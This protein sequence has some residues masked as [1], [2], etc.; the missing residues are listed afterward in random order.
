M[1]KKVLLKGPILTASGY[2]EHCRMIYRSL[3][4]ASEQ[5]DLFLFPTPWGQTGW[6]TSDDQER[7]DIDALIQKSVSYAQ[8]GGL[9]DVSV[10]VMIP[11]EFERMAPVNIG[12]TAG[13]ETNKVSPDWLFKAFETV[14]KMIVPSEFS[15]MGFLNSSAIASDQNGIQ[16]TIRYDKPIEVI[17]YPVKNI[18]IPTESKS[19][20]DFKTDFNFL[21]VAQWGPRKNLENTI[22]WFVEEFRNE[23]N[24]GLVVKATKLKGSNID[25]EF[26]IDELK[27]LLN[28][29]GEHKCKVYLLHGA[30]SEEDMHSL[31]VHPKIKALVSFSHGEGYGLPL[32][33]AAYSAL[34]VITHDFGGQK[35][36]L[37]VL[38]DGKLKFKAVKV[39]YDVKNIQ[40][41]AHWPTVLNPDMFWA[42]PRSVSCKK[43]MREV[44]KDYGRFKAQA[45]KLKEAI[46]AN[47]DEE[48]VHSIFISSLEEYIKQDEA[49]LEWLK[50]LDSTQVD[51]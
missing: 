11:S 18:K 10:Q 27:T 38:E 22:K 50:M 46:V 51:K 35:D 41:E 43:T 39:E 4:K 45:K 1:K 42:F 3:Q 17:P 26:C 30:L 5:V 2:G 23:E 14:D 29:F 31:Y 37:S 9:F 33:E 8:Q 7:R 15:K 24:V 25:R 20:V 6:L 28:T 40:P 36:F 47:Y 48:K 19:I 34:P 12:V 16:H 49:T 44:Y 32:F 21:T 13:I